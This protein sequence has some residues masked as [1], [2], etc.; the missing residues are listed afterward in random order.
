MNFQFLL[1]QDPQLIRSKQWGKR[2]NIMIIKAMYRKM[3]FVICR[4][5]IKSSKTAFQI[6]IISWQ[7]NCE[8]LITPYFDLEMW[9]FSRRHINGSNICT[10]AINL[11]KLSFRACDVPGKKTFRF[12]KICKFSRVYHFFLFFKIKVRLIFQYFI[13]KGTWN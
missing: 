10:R 1:A 8:V 5:P 4:S 9:F 7:Q 13:Q 6:K 12:L 11:S 2:W 3:N